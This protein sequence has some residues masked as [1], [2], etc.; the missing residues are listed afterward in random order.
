MRP[1]KPKTSLVRVTV[2]F[3]EDVLKEIDGEIERNFLTRTKWF[4][5][6]AVQKLDKD[7]K[8]YVDYVVKGTK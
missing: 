1:M 5:D 8:R 7:K 3:P 6:A 2:S 4:L